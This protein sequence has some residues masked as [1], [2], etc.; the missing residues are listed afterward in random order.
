M[1]ALYEFNTTARRLSFSLN[2]IN[3]QNF[4]KSGFGIASH[5]IAD[6]LYADFE[7]VRLRF[8]PR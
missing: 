5:L 4:F 7:L 1:G 2:V 6:P 8:S 3:H